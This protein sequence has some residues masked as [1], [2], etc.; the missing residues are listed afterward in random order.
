[1]WVI[2]IGA[3]DCFIHR[4]NNRK[5]KTRKDMHNNIMYY[6]ICMGIY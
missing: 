2:K 5:K 6:L 3:F 1:M 4:E